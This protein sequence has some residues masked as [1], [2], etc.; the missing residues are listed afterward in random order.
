MRVIGCRAMTVGVALLLSA[1]LLRAQ[2]EK[3]EPKI[4]AT[5]LAKQSQNP[6]ANLVSIPF[7]FNFN[8]GGGLGDGT[9]FNLFRT[10]SWAVGPTAVLL[11]MPGHFV[12]GGLANQLWTFAD[13]GGDPDVNQLLIQ[14][15]I[16][17]NFAR[18]WAV[19]FAPILTADW[20]AAS[21]QEWTVPLG[22]GLTKT[23]VFNRRPMTIGGQYYYNVVRP[24]AGPSSQLRIQVALLYPTGRP[25]APEKPKPKE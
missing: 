1:T 5:A 16:N 7:Q 15:F 9:L 19:T 14:P 23:T 25:V 6:V 13:A 12:L 8:T 20:N 17:Y 11:A 24:D 18:G 4:D 3:P 21:G 10:G 2:E 22:L